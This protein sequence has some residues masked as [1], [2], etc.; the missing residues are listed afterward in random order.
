M[1]YIKSLTATLIAS[2]VFCTFSATTLASESPSYRFVDLGT[3]GGSEAAALDIND[4]GVIVGWSTRD[5]NMGCTSPVSKPMNCEYAFKYQDGVMIDL[6]HSQ[7]TVQSSHAVAINNHSVAVGYEILRGINND[8]K[9]GES[10]HQPV[11]F[12]QGA[13]QALPVLSNKPLDSAMAADINDQGKIIGWADNHSGQD[14]L[15]SWQ[16]NI[17]STEAQHNTYYRRATGLNNLGDIIGFEYEA[18]SYKPNRAFIYKHGQVSVIDEH[19]GVM[20]EMNAINDYGMIAGSKMVRAMTPLKATIWY[21]SMLG[22][23]AEHVV[24]GLQQT[25][26]EE[27][28]FND[29]NRSGTAVGFSSTSDTIQATVYYRGKLYDLNRLVSVPG[30]L[31]TA[32]AVNE[33]GDIVG[34]YVNKDNQRRAFLLEVQ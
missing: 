19:E 32:E 3:L 15:V 27:S 17:I 11:R 12:E 14:T 28:A 33:R 23:V 21:P 10:Y 6:G 2:T 26:R 18:W 24:G 29:I 5:N 30:W 20:S 16:N 7:D 9:M 8:T 13:P 25:S 22:G 1:Y 4:L 34:I 31:Q